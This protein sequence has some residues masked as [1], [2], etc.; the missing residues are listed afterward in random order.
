MALRFSPIDRFV[1]T[2]NAEY[3]RE[4][5]EAALNADVT[6]NSPARPGEEIPA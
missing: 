1:D 6:S 2:L 4:A 5:A 3:D